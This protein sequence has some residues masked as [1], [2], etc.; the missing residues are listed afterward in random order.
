MASA[1]LGSAR[2][3]SRTRAMEG[4]VEV[5][6]E[7]GAVSNAV[8]ITASVAR[9]DYALQGGAPHGRLGPNRRRDVRSRESGLGTVAVLLSVALGVLLSVALFVSYDDLL[10]QGMPDHVHF[11]QRAKGDSVD[12]GQE[13]LG[14]GEPASR[15]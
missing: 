10:H 4:D 5:T 3:S 9:D 11:G 12:A 6:P 13:Q 14:L 15:L 7:A 2:N 8:C 1:C